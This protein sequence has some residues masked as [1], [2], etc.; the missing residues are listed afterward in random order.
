V[1]ATETTG[2]LI[3][4]WAGRVSVWI[5]RLGLPTSYRS[6]RPSVRPIA[7]VFLEER[8]RLDGEARIELVTRGLSGRLTSVMTTRC[9]SP[10]T[11][12]REF[13]ENT[14]R[15]GAEARS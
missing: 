6:V 12:M 11:R 3:E 7:R 14:S 15:G 8:A 2:T 9:R 10:K 13:R 4:L 5:G 1:N